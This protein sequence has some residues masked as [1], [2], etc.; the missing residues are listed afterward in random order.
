[1]KNIIRTLM[2]SRWNT[3]VLA[4]LVATGASAQS[5]IYP[6]HFD[7]EQVTLLDGPLKTAMDRNIGVLLQYDVERLLTPY[8]RQAGL[9]A[10]ADAQSRYY[11]WELLHPNFE[12]WGSGNFRLDGHVGGH[13]MTALALAYAAS[14]DAGVKAQIKER[15]DNMLGVLQDCQDVFDQ[16]SDGM[17][18]FIGG[19]P[20]NDAWKATYA[21]NVGNFGVCAVPLYCQHKILAGL[22]DLYLY[23]EGAESEKA[24]ELYLKLCDWHVN[25]ISNLND[26]QVQGWLGT[27]HGGINETLADAYRIFE[28]DKYLTAAKRYSHMWEV[29]GLQTLNTSF[30]DNQHANTQVPKFIGF[31][32]IAQEDIT[33]TNF[34][35]AALNFWTDVAENRTVCIGGNSVNEH[36]LSAAAGNRYIDET[37]GPESCNTNNMMK[38]SEDLFDNTHE[39]KY[40]DFY[41]AATWNHILSTQDPTT[42]NYV[43]FTPMRPQSY[44]IYSQV[45]QD[46]WCCVGTGMEN[47][48]KYG[49]FVYTHSGDVL[50][51]NLFTASRLQDDRFALTQE[52]QFPY[53]QGTRITI[54]KA[55]SYTLAIRRPSWVAE[56]FAV[57]VNGSNVNAAAN[58]QG[59]VE[60]Q[61]NWQVGDVVTVSLPM[62]LR[63]EQCPNQG[64]Y[65]AF[66]YGPV[67]LAARTTKSTGDGNENSE[68][69]E[70]SASSLVYEELPHEYAWGER[71]G[72]A[73]DSYAPKKALST[74]PMLIGERGEVLERITPVST[75][76]LTF[77][78]DVS[79]SDEMA[80]TYEWNTLTLQPFYTLHHSRVNNYFYQARLE[81]YASSTWAKEELAVL[82]LDKQ[83]LCSIDVGQQQAEA[84][85]VTYDVS[86]TSG[87]YNDESYRDTK[88]DGFIQIVMDNDEPEARNLSLVLRYNVADKGRSC[89]IYVNDEKLCDYVVPESTQNQNEKG[90]Y[91]LELPLGDKAYDSDGKA[92]SRFTVKIVATS[93]AA[94]GLYWIRLIK[95]GINVSETPTA[96]NVE[97]VTNEGTYYL[98]NVGSGMWL[99]SGYD[100]GT[101]AEA[102]EVGCPVQLAKVCDNVYKIKMNV[103]GTD[104]GLFHADANIWT[105][106]GGNGVDWTF[107]KTADGYY[108]IN[109]G[110]WYMCSAKN[111]VLP[112]YNPTITT[113][114]AV[115]VTNVPNNVGLYAKW[116]IVSADEVSSQPSF[117]LKNPN[118]VPSYQGANWT[119]MTGATYNNGVAEIYDATGEVS[120]TIEV[121]NDTYAVSAHGFYRWNDN[122]ETSYTNR[123]DIRAF[124]FAN[125]N[126]VELS[127]IMESKVTTGGDVNV[128][129]GTATYSYPFWPRTASMYFEQG[130]YGRKTVYVNVTDGRLNLGLS[131]PTKNTYDWTI[132]DNVF[133]EKVEDCSDEKVAFLNAASDA[134]NLYMAYSNERIPVVNKAFLAAIE[135][136]GND[137][138]TAL[139]D[140]QQARADYLSYIVL[141]DQQ[142]LPI[143]T[144]GD[145]AYVVLNRGLKQGWN[146]LCLPFATTAEA[147]AGADAVAYGFTSASEEHELTFTQVETMAA[148]TPYLFYSS[149]KVTNPL[150]TRV[151]LQEASPLTVTPDG[152]VWSFVG[153]YIPKM[154][155]NGYYGVTGDKVRLAG[156]G[157]TLNGMRAYLTGPAN[158]VASVKVDNFGLQTTVNGLRTMENGQQVIYDLSGRRVNKPQ[159]GIY[160]INGKKVMK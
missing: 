24:K 41:E 31:A 47:H 152:S 155:M 67:L 111:G 26:D 61:R 98:Y 69:E 80:S 84:G 83:S 50:Y 101:H 130:N 123:A 126:K 71:M 45:N 94:P 22:R 2:K 15:I 125:E 54:D 93:W 146:T 114:N 160:I 108:T 141:S 81:D 104:R 147:V 140:L 109:E 74:M 143:Y 159:K 59:Y 131:K 103:V 100:Y 4:S 117:K 23:T 7:L 5:E 43:Y 40:A 14:H 115:N 127:S 25:L 156:S 76:E 82:E 68:N 151:T 66:K 37:N 97:E 62:S 89:T 8:V 142:T 137:Y 56:G 129:V 11:R 78:L 149:A 122:Y 65:I 96:T 19:Q 34:N 38:L 53:E 12:N 16:S 29:N 51:V 49:H 95:D 58:A 36:F 113:K 10:T 135:Y 119:T 92:L 48:S 9:S 148:N 134:R 64:D 46:M 110:A 116:L 118:F 133:V 112:R 107:T 128:N 157:S 106:G 75:S 57:K 72:H 88:Q 90:F 153:N 138:A 85:A 20:C 136:E 60:V 1:M 87:N 120:Q 77:T 21:G 44:R 18:G 99:G 105:D 27:E 91:N 42:G 132:M 28:D 39:A 79:R 154:D 17:Y 139:T 32:R 63:Y 124:L 73:P 86:S 70:N 6:Q 33:A 121:E 3:L 55:G 52:T 158:A 150:F 30:L 145:F 102:K 144:T 35:T 13:Y